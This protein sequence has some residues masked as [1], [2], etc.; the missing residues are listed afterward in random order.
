M[1]LLTKLTTKTYTCVGDVDSSLAQINQP[2]SRHWTAFSI[3]RI[4]LDV[5]MFVDDKLHHSKVWRKPH[6]RALVYIFT[7]RGRGFIYDQSIS[8]DIPWFS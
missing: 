7:G 3:L 8:Y 5:E 2:C 1:R 6:L 4:L